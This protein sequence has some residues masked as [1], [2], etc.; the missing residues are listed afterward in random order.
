GGGVHGED[1]QRRPFERCWRK[2]YCG[3]S[4]RDRAVP[5][6]TL[7]ARVLIV[8]CCPCP[9]SCHRSG[10]RAGAGR[11][12]GFAEVNERYGYAPGRPP[13]AGLGRLAARVLPLLPSTKLDAA[14]YVAERVRR[15]TNRP[16][17]ATSISNYP[18][19]STF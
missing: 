3:T 18:W 9:A 14:W 17:R 6:T 5:R 16:T 15:P 1:E 7:M 11:Q 13:A 12:D 2:T 4:T 19:I 8:R 10:R